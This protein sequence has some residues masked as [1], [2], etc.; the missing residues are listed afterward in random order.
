MIPVLTNTRPFAIAAAVLLVLALAWGCDAK[1][2][3]TVRQ[4]APL[5]AATL[6]ST[7]GNPVNIP[8]DMKGGLTVLLFWS[9]GCHY[10]EKEMPRIEPLYEKY[11]AGGFNFLAIHM[12]PGMDAS[13]QMKAD[14]SL[15][16]PMAVDEKSSLGKL[17]G[18]V[19]VPTM[20][21]LDGKGIVREKILGGLGAAD[22]EK[23][24]R[25]GI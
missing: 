15:T 19:S 25:E 20:F 8:A 9:Q 14:M 7:E 6:P 5:P 18:I 23:L 17:Y 16:F 24:I 4:G 22:L 2:G 1:K 12:G 13:R 10:C 21:V 11:H 3:P